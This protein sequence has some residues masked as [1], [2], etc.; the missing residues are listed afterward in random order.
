MAEHPLWTA[1]NVIITPH[2]GGFCDVYAE[3]AMP[4]IAHNMACF[5]RGDLDGMVNVVRR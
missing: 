5:L 4:T 3:R 1:R 2:L